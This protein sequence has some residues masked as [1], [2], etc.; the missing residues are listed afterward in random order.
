[1]PTVNNN[2]IKD[3]LQGP[4]C[5]NDGRASAEITRKLQKN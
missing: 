1:M 5:K 2:A 4:N 3:F